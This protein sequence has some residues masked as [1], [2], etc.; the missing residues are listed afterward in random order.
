MSERNEVISIF[1]EIEETVAKQMMAEGRGV[2]KLAPTASVS[3]EDLPP[4]TR[5][6]KRGDPVRMVIVMPRDLKTEF[7]Q[8]VEEF[9]T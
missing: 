1:G 7:E 6:N 5:W 8:R 4:S 3:F 9:Q 2:G